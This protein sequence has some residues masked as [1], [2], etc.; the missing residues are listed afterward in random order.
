M[1]GPCP[2]IGHR[3]SDTAPG[4][5]A[6]RGPPLKAQ[7]LRGKD[8][9]FDRGNDHRG[10]LV[11]DREDVG[12]GAIVTLGP[13]MRA[14]RG[15]DE[16]ARN[17]QAIAGLANASF[18][19]ILHAKVSGDLADVGGLSLVGEARIAGDH[20]EPPQLRQGGNDI[21]CDA[22]AEIILLRVSAHVLERKNRN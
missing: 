5:Q 21:F 10:D 1:C 13:D 20:E 3:A 19:N 4:I 12:N 2:H 14:G 18:Q 9:R 16:L 15:I 11:L 17:A 8:L 6:L 22:V 7:V